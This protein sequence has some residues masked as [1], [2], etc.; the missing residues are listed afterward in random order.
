MTHYLP[1]IVF[2]DLEASCQ[3][4]DDRPIEIGVS[5]ID[6]TDELVTWSSLVPPR[7]IWPD[8][9][10]SDEC[11]ADHGIAGLICR[12]HPSRRTSTAKLTR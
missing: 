4:V 6:E 5:R 12:T 8:T 2:L 1:E 7:G 9:D 11:E 3:S 10:R